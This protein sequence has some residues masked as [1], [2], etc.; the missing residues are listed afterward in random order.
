MIPDN[1]TKWVPLSEAWV[2]VGRREVTCPLRYWNL[3]ISCKIWHG[4]SLV[5]G[6]AG[7]QY[8]WAPAG[9]VGSGHAAGPWPL[10]PNPMAGSM[11]IALGP[12]DASAL[13]SSSYQKPAKVLVLHL[14]ESNIVNCPAVK[15]L[16]KLGEDIYKIKE[17]LPPIKIM[18]AVMLTRRV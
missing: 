10:V 18:W 2:A 16:R 15:F 5:P 9:G 7:V 1:T 11:R 3:A 14:G 12:V 4:I 17:L 6:N 13:Q 8:L